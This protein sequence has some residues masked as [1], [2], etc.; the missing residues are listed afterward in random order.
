[1]EI[2]M[3][4][5]EHGVIGAKGRLLVLVHSQVFT[6]SSPLPNVRECERVIFGGDRR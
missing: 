2:S 4:S 3:P 6:S 1:M 5:L